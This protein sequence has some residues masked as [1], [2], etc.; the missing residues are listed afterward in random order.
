MHAQINV[1]DRET[2]VDATVH[3]EKYR[4]LRVR[5]GG[6]SAYFVLLSRAAQEIHLKRTEHGF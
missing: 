2:L 4:N 1:I 5:M 3:P 6:W